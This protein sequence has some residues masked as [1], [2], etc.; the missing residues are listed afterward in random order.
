MQL[1]SMGA[2]AN[3]WT[4]LRR[5][6]T[7]RSTI[8]ACALCNLPLRSNHRHL[9]E[10]LTR[11]VVCACDG[12]ALR[13]PTHLAGKFKLIPRDARTLPSLQFTDVQWDSLALPTNLAFFFYDKGTQRVRAMYPSP[14]GA[15]ES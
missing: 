6:A 1:N 15:T 12:C 13:F 11:Q 14:A 3:P 10:A 2:R 5:L 8:D 7:T 4:A 9:L